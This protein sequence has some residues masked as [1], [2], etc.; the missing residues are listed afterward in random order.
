MIIL[1]TNVIS[2]A[3]KPVPWPAVIAWLDSTPMDE[4]YTSAVTHAELLYGVQILPAGKLRRELVTAVAAALARFTT[5][6]LP[7]DSDAAVLF[8]GLVA[9]RRRIGRP[10]EIMDA[11]IAAIALAHGATLAT[12]DAADFAHCGLRLINPWRA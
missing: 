9:N 4:L 5:P 7:F 8:A 3:A 12:R 1:D 10:V 6:I 2:E 11:Q